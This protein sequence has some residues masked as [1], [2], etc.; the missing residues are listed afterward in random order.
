MAVEP[1]RPVPK[2]KVFAVSTAVLLRRLNFTDLNRFY[3][4]DPVIANK[5]NI[6]AAL[7]RVPQENKAQLGL[8]FVRRL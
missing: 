2:R 6:R 7:F 8:S 3:R 1:P 4:L 5:L